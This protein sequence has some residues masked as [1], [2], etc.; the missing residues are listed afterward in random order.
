MK[1][2]G[3]SVY[4]I[5]AFL[6]MALG[7]FAI[8]GY[9][10]FIKPENNITANAQISQGRNTAIV[11]AVQAVSPAVV[12]ITNKGIARDF[13]NRPVIVDQGTGSG[14]IFDRNGYIVTNYHV[15]AKAQELIV[16][17]A[18][19]RILEGKIVGIDPLTDLA[20]VKI[21]AGNLPVAPFGDS[22]SLMVGEPAIAIG[23]PLGLDLKGTVTAGIISALDRTID[24]G[25]I[26][27]KLIQTDA[28]INPGNSGGA[29]INAD[30]FVV[31]I[32]SVKISVVGVEGLG[33]AIPIND[34]HP[35]LV[36]LIEKGRVIRPY[37]GINLVDKK[38]ANRNGYD[39]PFE[40]GVFISA[41]D[42]NGSA[43]KAGI[44]YSDLIVN[45]AGKKI[46]TISDFTN[47][48]QSLQVNSEVEVIVLRNK[49]T[50]TFKVRLEEI[51]SGQ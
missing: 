16:S 6:S 25:D 1:I 11:K 50:L 19:G 3:F 18:D 2:K 49:E 43:S 35:I 10:T 13:Y 28:A 12:S 17:L 4:I 36:S 7:A 51:P 38:L 34:A 45:V 20:V 21:E 33:F 22:D 48:I 37:W 32:N 14:I 40:P 9:S 30:G 41:I 46:V 29:L 44:I 39:F 23:N 15:V 27:L 31:G 26:S 8:L 42:P 5:V 24:I 47:V